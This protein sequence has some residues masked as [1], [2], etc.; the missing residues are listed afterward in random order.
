M[1]AETTATQLLCNTSSVKF[2]W[3]TML[4]RKTRRLRPLWWLLLLAIG[5]GVLWLS[6]GLAM[7]NNYAVLAAL[8]EGHDDLAGRRLAYNRWLHGAIGETELMRARLARHR[9]D[10]AQ[11]DQHL[12]LAAR[13]GFPADR[14]R[15]EQSL[16]MA[17]TGQLDYALESRLNSWIAGGIETREVCSAYANGLAASSQFAEA[18]QVLEAWAQDFPR[19]PRPTFRQGRILE[20]QRRKDEALEMYVEAQR[21]DT[22]FVPASYSIAKILLE[23]R[24]VDEALAA[25]RACPDAENSIPIQTGIAMCLKAQ[26]K[27]DEAK[28][29]LEDVLSNSNEIIFA[30]YNRVDDPTER[31]VAAAELGKID[32]D[33]GNFAQSK[34]WLERAIEVNPRDMETRYTYAV[35]LRGLGEK[36]LADKEFEYVKTT[37]EAL[38]S[39][40]VLWDRIDSEPSNTEARLELARILLEHESKRAGMYW[41]KSILQYDP[42]NAAVAE[43]LKEHVQP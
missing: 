18:H 11:M 15:R 14:I 20:H 4:A 36:E 19:D 30:A 42:D 38:A 27:L 39:V 24:K 16:A 2:L 32:S 25:F 33:Q 10:L 6:G 26:G 21:R 9:G 13:N 23:Q 29:I 40:N 37:R 35:T 7:L 28:R 12:Q 5:L 3:P 17:Q 8:N 22:S 41:L 31:L 34:Q 1:V 43:L